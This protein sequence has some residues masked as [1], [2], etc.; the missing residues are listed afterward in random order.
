MARPKPNAIHR[1]AIAAWRRGERIFYTG[2]P[3]KHG[4]LAGRYYADLQCVECR[5]LSI[6]QQR[7]RADRPTR[8]FVKMTPAQLR[9]KLVTDHAVSFVAAFLADGPKLAREVHGAAYERGVSTLALRAAARRLG[10]HYNKGWKSDVALVWWC[11]PKDNNLD[12]AR[13]YWRRPDA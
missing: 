1:Q 8:A 3:C 9:T 13:S 5:R 2:E 6:E 4:H 10:V 11:L 12:V 7:A